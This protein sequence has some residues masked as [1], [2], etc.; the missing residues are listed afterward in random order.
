M[1]HYSIRDLNK[2][3]I[4]DT[5][6]FENARHWASFTTLS[7]QSAPWKEKKQITLNDFKLRLE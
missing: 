6:A 4:V 1:S 3:K 7:Y 2:D 5:S